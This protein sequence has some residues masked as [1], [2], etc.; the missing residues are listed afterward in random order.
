[1]KILR[2]AL[3]LTLFF[4]LLTGLAF[5]LLITG[6]AQ[7]LFPGQANGSMVIAEGKVVGSSL[8]GQSFSDEK[9][10]HPRPS[11]GGYDAN[12]SGGTNLGPTNPKLL[13]GADGFDGVKQLAAQYRAFN[14]VGEDVVLPADAVTRSGS[15]LDP[16]ISVENA[17]LQAGRVARANQVEK[18][19]IEALIGELAETPLLGLGEK[20]Y[21]NVLLLN[22]AVKEL[23]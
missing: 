6:I 8:I 13:Q 16:H 15:G 7:A 14:A 21:V 19:R 23:K 9:F 1:M 4:V 3:V 5:P 11:S 17:L 2:P 18:A 20:R 10:F 12:N 22:R